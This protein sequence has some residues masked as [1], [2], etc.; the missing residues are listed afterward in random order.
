[1]LKKIIL[2]SSF[3]ILLFGVI[4]LPLIANAQTSN[5]IIDTSSSS[6]QNGSYSLND[7]MLIVIRVSRWVLGIVGSLSLIM[8]IYG[9]FT[10]LISAGSSEKVGQA[11]KIIIAA[12]IG[13]VIVFSSFLIIQFVL[14]SLGLNWDGTVSKMTISSTGSATVDQCKALGSNYSCMNITLGDGCQANLCPNDPDIV[15]CCYP[16]AK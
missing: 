12:V 5:S 16:R 14:K 3:L 10:F 9:G 7:M 1:M 8:F 13:L 2:V 6:Y 11:Q 4:S 15:Q